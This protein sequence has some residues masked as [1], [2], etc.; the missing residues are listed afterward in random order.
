MRS[1]G[2]NT[3]RVLRTGPWNFDTTVKRTVMGVFFSSGI[4]QRRD[5]ILREDDLEPFVSKWPMPAF[6]SPPFFC[7]PG[8]QSVSGGASGIGNGDVAVSISIEA[9]ARTSART[10]GLLTVVVLCRLWFATTMIRLSKDI[11]HRR[12]RKFIGHGYFSVFVGIEASA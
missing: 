2:K 6:S 9:A 1:T 5:V 8:L 7:G 12:K 3:A 10:F 11:V 4:C